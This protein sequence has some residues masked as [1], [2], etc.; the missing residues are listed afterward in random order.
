V[1][2]A[3][4]KICIVSSHRTIPTYRRDTLPTRNFLLVGGRK[5]KKMRAHARPLSMASPRSHARPLMPASLHSLAGVKMSSHYETRCH[6]IHSELAGLLFIPI[7]FLFYHLTFYLTTLQFSH[8]NEQQQFA[9]Q[10]FLDQ[11]CTTSPA[12]IGVAG[13][14]HSRPRVCHCSCF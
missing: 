9:H 4:N 8:Q 7:I 13:W 12:W 11:S 3:T 1:S 14:E 10:I 6:V 2:T 5:Q